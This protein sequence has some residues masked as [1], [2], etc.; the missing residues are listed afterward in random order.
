[1]STLQN[2]TSGEMLGWLNVNGAQ[3]RIKVAKWGQNAGTV[4]AKCGNI[5]FFLGGGAIRVKITGRTGWTYRT[6][7]QTR[8][9]RGKEGGLLFNSLSLSQSSLNFF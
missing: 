1:M 2:M 4:V 3:Y 7:R 6:Q 8:K 9:E 5:F